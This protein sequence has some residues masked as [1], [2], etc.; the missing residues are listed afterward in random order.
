M[1]DIQLYL[2]EIVKD[3]DEARELAAQSANR[4]ASG[5][6]RLLQLIESCGEYINSDEPHLRKN[7]LAYLAD[8][9]A[10]VPPKVLSGQQRR[11]LC[12]FIL[13]RVKD[14]FE[15]TGECA[16]ALMA[17]EERGKWDSE[18]AGEIINTFVQ[19]QSEEKIAHTDSHVASLLMLNHYE[20]TSSKASVL[21]FFNS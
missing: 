3:K 19:G 6:L 7:S 11:L 12:D 13:S 5:E 2:V 9:L 15:G 17:L 20:L 21:L 1:S 16:K 8:V 4:L 18:T 10:Q 14:D